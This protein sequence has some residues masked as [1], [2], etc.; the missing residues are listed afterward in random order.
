MVFRLWV[1]LEM[2]ESTQGPVG[3]VMQ[4]LTGVIPITLLLMWSC[5]RMFKFSHG[6]T[7]YW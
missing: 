7:R 2:V 3:I 1:A 5:V 6:D 4:W